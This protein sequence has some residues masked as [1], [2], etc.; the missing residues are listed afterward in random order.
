MFFHIAPMASRPV[1]MLDPGGKAVASSVYNDATPAKSPLLNNS[2]H[3]AFTASISAFWASAGSDSAIK[4]VTVN[5]NRNIRKLRDF[6]DCLSLVG[7]SRTY[8]EAGRNV[9]SGDV[10]PCFR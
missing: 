5:T 3:C 1:T 6:R 8:S 2:S 7:L 9:G 10:V 4:Q